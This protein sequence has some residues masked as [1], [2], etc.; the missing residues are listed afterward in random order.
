[1]NPLSKKSS[2]YMKK[3][4]EPFEDH[5]EVAFCCRHSRGGGSPGCLPG[6][7]IP[8]FAGMTSAVRVRFLKWSNRVRTGESFA[9]KSLVRVNHGK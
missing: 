7:W 3:G 9:S 4:E 8:A 5:S 2:L 6:V 1:M